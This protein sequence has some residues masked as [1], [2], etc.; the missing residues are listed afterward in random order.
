M[1]KEKNTSVSVQ[2]GHI[3]VKNK[4]FKISDIVMFLVCVIISLVIWIY[5]TN[6]EKKEAQKLDNIQGGV[7][8][9]PETQNSLLEE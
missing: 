5:A 4:K 3:V 7:Q 9:V 2:E 8:V 1:A 6:V